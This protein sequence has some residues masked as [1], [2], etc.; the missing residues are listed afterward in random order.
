MNI[1]IT[2]GAGSGKST[3]VERLKEF[4]LSADFYSMDKFIDE[5]YTNQGWLDWLAEEFDTTNRTEISRLAF[6]DKN[7]LTK[8][9]LKS[10]YW[11]GVQLGKALEQNCLRRVFVEFPLLLEANLQS[12]FDIIVLITANDEV[13][14]QRIVARGKKTIEEARALIAAQMPES[15]K[16]RHAHVVID[17]SSDSI[18]VCFENLISRMDV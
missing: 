14:A 5:L 13:R 10:A 17:T 4:Y 11:V 18:D 8:L 2:G 9:N 15:E 6:A 7:I 16:K 12:E 1:A 3:L